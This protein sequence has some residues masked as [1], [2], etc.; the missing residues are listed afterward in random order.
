MVTFDL[1]TFE[2]SSVPSVVPS[3]SPFRENAR[4]KVI[5]LILCEKRPKTYSGAVEVLCIA[6]IIHTSSVRASICTLPEDKLPT[7][8]YKA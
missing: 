8:C 3:F 7:K 2:D 6:P 1:L 5:V 4:C